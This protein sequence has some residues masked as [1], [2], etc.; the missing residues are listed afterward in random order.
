MA[1]QPVE[2]SQLSTQTLPNVPT[3]P[4]KGYHSGSASHA[5]EIVDDPTLLDSA[6]LKITRPLGLLS[7]SNNP[8]ECC[9]NAK[10]GIRA[11]LLTSIIENDDTL[12]DQDFHH[13]CSAA[14]Q[15]IQTCWDEDERDKWSQHEGDPSELFESRLI[16]ADHWST[17]SKFQLRRSKFIYKASLYLQHR[18]PELDNQQCRMYDL[19]D[20]FEVAG[21]RSLLNHLHSRNVLPSTQFL[22]STFPDL[23][24]STALPYLD[25]SPSSQGSSSEHSPLTSY[26]AKN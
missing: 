12:L 21:L 14:Q 26:P 20:Q 13:L 19:D 17:V 7:V 3:I 8:H 25:D 4:S 9:H 16:H 23:L 6:R 11:I 15:M 22:K 24:S 5:F 18:I 2:E 10:A 1:S